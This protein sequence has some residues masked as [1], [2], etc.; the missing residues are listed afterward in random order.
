MTKTANRLFALTV[1]IFA[2]CADDPSEPAETAPEQSS[3]DRH[4]ALGEEV[5]AMV[6]AGC[7]EGGVAKAPHK[8]M[9]KIMSPDSILDITPST[10]GTKTSVT[11]RLK[12]PSKGLMTLM[13][14]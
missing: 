13:S 12:Q 4:I 14:I 6:C 10:S 9:M 5:Y 1:F 11:M 3:L 2:G 7:H 8:E